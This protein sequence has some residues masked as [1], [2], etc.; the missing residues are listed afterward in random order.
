MQ[1]VALQFPYS[2]QDAIIV[3]QKSHNHCKLLLGHCTENKI[4][5]RTMH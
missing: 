2:N 5:M 4:T 1:A 3:T